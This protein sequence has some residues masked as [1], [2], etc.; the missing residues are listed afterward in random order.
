MVTLRI[1][2][3][4]G[5]TKMGLIKLLREAVPGTSLSVAASIANL[6]AGGALLEGVDP[7]AVESLTADLEELGLSAVVVE[8]G[9]DG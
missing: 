9:A 3:D 5:P 1:T 4:S 8:G 7:A 6:T 2:G